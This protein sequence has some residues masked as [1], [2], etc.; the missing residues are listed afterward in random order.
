MIKSI[1]GYRYYVNFIDDHTRKVWIY[2]MKHKGEM[3]Q[4]FLS[5][6][7]MVEKDESMR[8]KC[9]RS[10]GRGEYF[11]NEFSE[12]LKEIGNSKEVFM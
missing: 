3:F 12:Y 8:M 11:S 10:Y 9:L 1:R 2:F 6:K 4:Y 5:F 7:A